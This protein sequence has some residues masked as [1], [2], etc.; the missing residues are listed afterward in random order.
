METNKNESL[1]IP[2]EPETNP[3]EAMEAKIT[4]ALSAARAEWEAAMETRLQQMLSESDR[5][6]RMTE[7]E[8]NAYQTSR[9]EA[10]LAARE[11]QLMERELR[12]EAI[13]ILAQRGLPRELADAIGYTGRDAMLLS[14]DNIERVFRK[15]VQA[16]IEQRM[17]GEIPAAGAPV[18]GDPGQ[19]GDEEYYRLNYPKNVGVVI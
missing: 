14:I 8:R 17:K 9:R 19:M 18:S 6:S 3:E 4:A 13:E 5:L 16:G 2:E 7:E 11:K 12:A 15:A 1:N 10:D